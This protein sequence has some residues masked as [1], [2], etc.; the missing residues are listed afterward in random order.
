MKI[1]IVNDVQM[2]QVILK[3]AVESGGR[4]TVI[5]IAEN[6]RI[7]VEKAAKEKPDVILMDIVMPEM[8]GVL[9]TKEI[10]GKTPCAILVVTSPISESMDEIFEAMGFG[11]LDVVKT[12]SF[13]LNS[14]EE[15]NELLAKLEMI[16]AL[17]GKKKLPP[18]KKKMQKASLLKE[19]VADLV[20]LGAST[21]G[22][23]ALIDVL[24]AYP[25]PALFA[26]VIIQHV[27]QEYSFAFARWME[28]QTG[29]PMLL[30]EEGDKPVNGNVYIA[31]R[32]AHLVIDNKGCF[33][34][35]TDPKS[36]SYKPSI[37]IFLSSLAEKWPKKAIAAI[38]T[39]MGDDGALGLKELREKGWLTL[40][41]ERESCIV[42]GMPKAA[43]K[44]EA[45]QFVLT[46][47]SIGNMI[48]NYF[49]RRE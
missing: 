35:S 31:K 32:N 25:R 41:Q 39:G 42:F 27:D 19:E 38:L 1:G 2:A 28:E 16:A 15:A 7:A 18:R 34:Y 3:H 43:I 11:A 48:V 8:D 30:I 37:N 33:S 13:G 10:M 23:I 49:S 21:G 4:H 26:T 6:G 9:A 36:T 46:P 44:L 17:L 40:A 29:L 24:E 47:K 14:S 45:A 20:V 22:P 12:P 5:W